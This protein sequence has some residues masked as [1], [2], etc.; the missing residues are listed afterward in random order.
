MEKGKIAEYTE[1]MAKLK[2]ERKKEWD[3]FYKKKKFAKRHQPNKRQK[4]SWKETLFNYKGNMGN[5]RY[6]LK[7]SYKGK[8]FY[9]K[10][11]FNGK[12]TEFMLRWFINYGEYECEDCNRRQG[13][14]IK[15]NGEEMQSFQLTS[16]NINT[17]RKM[18]EKIFKK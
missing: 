15:E 12:P 8:C 4:K 9:C 6:E 13:I 17:F 16:S 18:P 7:K 2:E 11:S 5:K 10:R 3:E 14:Y 1:K